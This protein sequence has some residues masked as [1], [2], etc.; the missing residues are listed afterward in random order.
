MQTTSITLISLLFRL[1]NGSYS[2]KEHEAQEFLNDE[3][4]LFR[5]L[6]NGY[7]INVRREVEMTKEIFTVAYVRKYLHRKLLSRFQSSTRPSI[8]GSGMA[9]KI[10]MIFNL[11]TILEE[12]A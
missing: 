12:S 7:N 2:D 6:F 1:G 3:A 11:L 8:N 10:E 9:T 4:I 5:K